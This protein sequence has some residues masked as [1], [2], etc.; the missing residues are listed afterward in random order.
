MDRLLTI[1]LALLLLSLGTSAQI[2]GSPAAGP[3]AETNTAP[4]ANHWAFA[5]VS[6]P[7]PPPVRDTSWPINPVD[8]F[9]LARLELAG[10]KPVRA[11]S[12]LEWLRRASFDLTGLPPTPKQVSAFQPD[13]TG[14]VPDSRYAAQVDEWLSSSAFGQRWARHWLDVARFAESAGKERNHLFPE[15][16][17]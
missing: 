10:L 8:S 3:G 2:S 13:D 7:E 1:P 15:A 6:N 11:A 17:R 16:W 12:P 9:I 14:T 5:P 4:K